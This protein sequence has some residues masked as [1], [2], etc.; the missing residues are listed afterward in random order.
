M[1]RLADFAV[2]PYPLFAQLRETQP[3][4]WAEDAHMWLLTRRE[5]VIQVLRDCETFRTDSARSTIHDTFGSQMLSAEGDRHRRYKSQCGGPF[6]ARAVRD[7]AVPLITSRAR[8]LIDAC[9][10]QPRV[11]L[12]VALASPLAI[13]TVATVLGIPES[14]HGLIRGWY[15][16]FAVA[17]AN[18]TWDEAVRERGRTSV[19]QFRESIAPILRS[20]AS[21]GEE[22][23]LAVLGRRSADRLSDDEIL[24]NAL[25]VLFGGIETT[26]STLLNVFWTLLRHPD[27]LAA[28]HHDRS[29]LPGAIE[30]AMRW[31][32][33][34]QS[35]TRHVSARVAMHGTTLNAGDVVQCMLGAANRDPAYFAEPDRYDI[36]RPNAGDHLSFGSG[37]HYCLGAALARAEV[38]VAVNALLDR[39]PTLRADPERP[40]APRG[41]EFRAPPTLWVMPRQ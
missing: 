9:A 32:P 29:L 41:Y 3:V 38:S 25:I 33:A 36:Y 24:A 14:L 17:L 27:A 30:E 18:F 35:C 5:D 21:A 10:S 19:R 31:E 34:V 15:D 40:S 16:D 23:L 2:D 13:Y 7:H 22:T 39:F 8:A 1:S 20:A 28:V 6:N 12:R 4:A 26:E 37:R 11:E